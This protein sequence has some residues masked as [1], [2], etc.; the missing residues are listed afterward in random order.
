[1]LLLTWGA[2]GSE[3]RGAPAPVAAAGG[4]IG[5]LG[6]CQTALTIQAAPRRP[7]LLTLLQAEQ[8]L[9]HTRAAAAAAEAEPVSAAVLEAE[10]TIELAKA[11]AKAAAEAYAGAIY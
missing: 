9:A 1:M 3:G 7:I 5:S 6:R 8:L 2:E 11:V 4:H 10:A